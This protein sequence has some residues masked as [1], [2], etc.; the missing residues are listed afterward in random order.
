[1][2]ITNMNPTAPNLHA[3]M[4]LHKVN[5]HVRPVITWKNDPAYELAKHLTKTTQLPTPTMFASPST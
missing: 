1:M 4:K 5:T 3:T 2:E